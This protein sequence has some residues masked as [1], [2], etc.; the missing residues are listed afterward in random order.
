MKTL[1]SNS[2]D[3]SKAEGSSHD[4]AKKDVKMKI[5][6]RASKRKIYYSMIPGISLLAALSLFPSIY[7]LW[8]SIQR[9]NL[10]DPLNRKIVGL[11]NYH[12]L[13]TDAEFWYSL[14]I[15]LIFVVAVVAI[16][17][18]FAYFLALLFFRPMPFHRLMRTLILLPMLTAPIVVG[19]LMRFMLDP[20]FGIITHLSEV[21]GF[22][23][24]DFLGTPTTALLSLIL[25][26]VWQWT[27]FLFLIFLA[28]M[29]GI[30][31]ELI[32]AAKLDGAKR[33][34][35][36]WHLFLPLMKYPLIVGITLRIIDSFRVYDLIYATT[37][38]GPI[39]ATTTMSWSIYDSGFKLFNVSLASAYSWLLLIVVVVI[40]SRFLKV[41][42]RESSEK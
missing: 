16:E 36:V 6:E 21:A 12:R 1:Q 38:G 14:K 7:S 10:S 35:L 20:Q 31:E 22:G 37:R 23:S 11:S 4:H 41:L 15:T 13:L 24:V 39:N 5:K 33:M 19:M 27:P 42:A 34:H 29:Q 2:I 17:S 26:D 25:V 9:W 3:L 40:T 18:V 32:E 8:V 30:P 28:A